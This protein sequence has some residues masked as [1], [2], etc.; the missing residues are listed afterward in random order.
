[1]RARSIWGAVA[2]AVAVTLGIPAAAFAAEPVTLE[3]SRV[4]DDSGVLDASGVASIEDAV[5]ELRSETGADLWVVYVD[6]FENPSDA[7]EWANTTAQTNGLGP[8]QYLLAVATEGRTY[9]LSG[10]SSGP[11][12]DEQLGE[13]EQQLVLPQ[14]QS[15]NWAGAGIAAAQGLTNAISGEDV[16]SSPGDGGG[17]SSGTV[18]IVLLVIVAIAIIL[19]IA[20]MRRRKKAAAVDPRAGEPAELAAV[21]TEDLG[22]QAGSAL[23]ET[24]DAVRTSEQELGFAIAQYGEESATTFRGAITTAK[25]TLSQAFTIQQRLDDAE[26]DTEQQVRAWN[27]EIIQLCTDANATL[28]QE[29]AAFDELRQIEKNAPDAVV[30]LR[31]ELGRVSGRTA[32]AEATLSRLSGTYSAAALG[33]VADNVAEAEERLRFAS[34]GLDAAEQD[35]AAGDLSSAAVDIRAAEDSIEQAGILLDAIDHAAADLQTA[36]QSIRA[37]STELQNDLQLAQSQPDPEGSLANV[38]GATEGILAEIEA[39]R[40]QGTYSPAEMVQRLQ[41]AN[42]TIDSVLQHVRDAEAQKRHAETLLGQSLSSAQAQVAAAEEYLTA[43]RGAV[44][45]EARTRLA[46]AGR[47][48]VLATQLQASDSVS[49]LAY[50]QRANDLAR[51]SMQYAQNDVS[52]FSNSYGLDG[53]MG[54]GRGS[55]D[56][57]MGAILGG[58]LI[59]QVLGGGGGGMFGGGGRSSG[60]FGGMGGFGGGRSSGRSAGSFGGSGSRSRRGGGRF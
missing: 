1:M 54:G 49:A 11:V 43:R 23:I 37:L 57:S 39:D 22:R 17:V 14:L 51:Q 24:D 34:T 2:L 16:A 48:L 53:M 25:A 21:S 58:I 7:A 3:S 44:G 32:P 38:I 4:L 41:A 10:D 55:S 33:A 28:D 9:Y 8:N 52:G 47:N 31:T 56:G 60:G 13:I 5:D 12:T 20:L 15:D 19:V 42:A 30:R 6:T 46:E 59:G 27:A 29:A 26:P 40:A 18:W 36:E 45:A 35:L 50:A